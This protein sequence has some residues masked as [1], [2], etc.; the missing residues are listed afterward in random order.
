MKSLADGFKLLRIPK[1]KAPCTF[2]AFLNFLK[3]IIPK[4]VE[5]ECQINKNTQAYKQGI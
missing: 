5:A 4:H 3:P 1:C 2:G